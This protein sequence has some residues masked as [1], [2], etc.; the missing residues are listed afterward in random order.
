[1]IAFYKKADK[2]SFS[3]EILH[4]TLIAYWFTVFRSSNK[5]IDVLCFP[6]WE[7][8]CISRENIGRKTVLLSFTPRWEDCTVSL[9]TRMKSFKCVIAYI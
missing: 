9:A 8:L 1:M 7:M 2:T 4:F 5:D 3:S 6:I